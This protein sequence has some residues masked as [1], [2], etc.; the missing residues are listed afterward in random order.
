MK[1]RKQ[2]LFINVMGMGAVLVLMVT[3]VLAYYLMEMEINSLVNSLC[4]IPGEACPTRFRYFFA[5]EGWGLF[6]GLVAIFLVL[7]GTLTLYRVSDSS[8]EK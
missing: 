8:A 3:A 5:T 2:G 1:S 6:W 7:S 4:R